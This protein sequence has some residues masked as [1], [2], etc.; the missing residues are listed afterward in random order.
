M[1]SIFAGSFSRNGPFTS[2]S[3]ILYSTMAASSLPVT[4]A[5]Q[6]S[7]VSS[8]S[9]VRPCASAKALRAF[10]A[11]SPSLPSIAPGENRARSRRTW[12]LMAAPSMLS[13]ESFELYSALL[14]AAASRLAATAGNTS[15]PKKM[16]ATNTR[17]IRQP[18]KAIVIIRHQQAL[19]PQVPHSRKTPRRQSGPLLRPL[20]HRFLHR[21]AGV[22]EIVCSID[23]RDMRQRL[24]EISG[25][26][27]FAGIEFLPETPEI[28]GHRTEAVD[29]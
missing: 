9:D 15:Q 1:S 26:A 4:S 17:I 27:A 29:P 19:G 28:A 21:L 25:L 11:F 2:L 20:S 18:R 6:T 24:R 23:Q 22:A 8:L 5:F 7:A 13:V 14:M 16:V 10:W 12:I 3:E